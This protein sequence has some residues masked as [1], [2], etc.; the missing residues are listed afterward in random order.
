MDANEVS[1][2]LWHER[3]LLELLCWKLEIVQLLLAAENNGA[4]PHVIVEIE[5]AAK[6]LRVTELDRSV[7]VS[8]FQR[9]SKETPTLS[10]LASQAPAGPWGDLLAEHLEAMAEL[11]TRIQRLRKTTAAFLT[12]QAHA[13]MD[14]YRGLQ[15]KAG[16][17]SR[18]QEGEEAVLSLRLYD[19][20]YQSALAVISKLIPATLTDF[21]CRPSDT[22]A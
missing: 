5:H 12:A 15:E 4:L 18:N 21:L 9:G 13:N 2:V 1:A 6:R 11:T 3:E 20:N 8:A 14:E 16:P 22:V 7:K 10:D 19:H 17:E